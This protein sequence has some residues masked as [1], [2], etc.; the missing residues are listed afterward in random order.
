MLEHTNFLTLHSEQYFAVVGLEN[1]A[2]RNYIKAVTLYTTLEFICS[3]VK[4]LQPN[5]CSIILYNLISN[6]LLSALNFIFKKQ[7]MLKVQEY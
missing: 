5:S 3:T 2:S 6:I 1:T 4:L 7:K